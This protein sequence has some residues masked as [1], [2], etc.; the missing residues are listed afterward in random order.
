MKV[1]DVSKISQEAIKDLREVK[2]KENLRIS[3]SLSK[4]SSEGVETANTVELTSQ[5]L[6][7]NAVKKTENL[8]E[9][10]EEKIRQIKSQIETGKYQVSNRE[11]ARAM[12]GS[13]LSEII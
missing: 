5:R 12:V 9:V 11:I 10:R 7:E 1:N 3:K 6:I 4:K 13:I 8:P 2:K